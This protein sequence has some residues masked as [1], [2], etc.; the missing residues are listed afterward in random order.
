MLSAPPSTSTVLI[1]VH[2]LVLPHSVLYSIGPLKGRHCSARGL[3]WRGTDGSSCCRRRATGNSKG[4][5][6]I[7]LHWLIYAVTR[8]YVRWHATILY[9]LAGSCAPYSTTCSTQRGPG[10]T[11]SFS[12]SLSHCPVSRSRLQLRRRVGERRLWLLVGTDGVRWQWN[13]RRRTTTRGAGGQR[14]ELRSLLDQPHRSRSA[15]TTRAKRRTRPGGR[16]RKEGTESACRLPRGDSQSSCLFD[17]LRQRQPCRTYGA[18]ASCQPHCA[19]H[20]APRPP[21]TMRTG[22]PMER[23]QSAAT[24]VQLATTRARRLRGLMWR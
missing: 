13:G 1:Q 12:V 20:S 4:K 3:H 23:E 16:R 19:S 11:R 18:V 2:L 22:R 5:A 6:G 14:R 24:S 10:Y 15:A 8:M 7:R 21:T 9:I 17:S